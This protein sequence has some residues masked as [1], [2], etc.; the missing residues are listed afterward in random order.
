[1]RDFIFSEMVKHKFISNEIKIQNRR[2]AKQTLCSQICIN[3]FKRASTGTFTRTRYEDLMYFYR[4]YKKPDGE[5]KK[6]FEKQ[7][8]HVLGI[9]DILNKYFGEKDDLLKNRSFI[10]SIFLFVEEMHATLGKSEFNKQMEMFVKFI[11]KVIH[12]LSEEI[13]LGIN[14]KNEHLYKFESYTSSAPGE[15]YRIKARHELIEKLFKNYKK[16]KK[17]LGD[18]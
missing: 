17:I 5:Q 18:K 16:T 12:R 4:E 7:I 9:L 3:S 6:F 8:K 2:F 13:K 14:R 10:I 11:Q 1:M 15:A